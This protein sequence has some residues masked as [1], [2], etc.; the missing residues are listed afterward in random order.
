M[1]LT[2]KVFAASALALFVASPISSVFADNSSAMNDSGAS[3]AAPAQS[4]QIDDATL[5][6]AAKA[7]VKVKQIVHQEK[8]ANAAEPPQASDQSQKMAAVKNEGL[9]PQQ[10]NQVLQMVQN[11]P[12]LEQKFATY[13]NQNGGDSD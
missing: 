12:Q 9:D 6:K 3:A 4:A 1:T 11:D 10:Y 13:V 5:Q 2:R 8:Q 7:Y